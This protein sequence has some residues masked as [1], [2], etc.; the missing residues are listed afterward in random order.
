MKTIRFSVGT[1]CLLASLLSTISLSA[2]ITTPTV[3]AVP[4]TTEA[5]K[6]IGA[7][8]DTAVT[9]GV[10][11]TTATSQ[12][13]T[14]STDSPDT[15]L[16]MAVAALDKGDKATTTQELQTGIAALE[17]S[18]QQKPTSFK[19]K[20]L[21]QVGK[22]KALLPLIPTGALGSGVLS[23]A[24]GLAKL[25]SGGN[26]LEGLMTAGSLIGKGSQLTS[27]LGGLSSAMSVLGGGGSAGKSL[28]SSA[29]G[30]VSKLDQG[31]M[32]AKAAE[33]AVKSQLGSVLNFVKGAL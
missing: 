15:H 20:V 29:L 21:A 13:A 14:Q 6:V 8:K 24:V 25:A 11:A 17:A 9:P 31:G 27:S 33:P 26:Q 12:A 3:P 28:I 18:V 22:L 30:S 5:P 19:D 32:V 10:A 2:Q 23:K 16:D 7:I 4:T 1:A